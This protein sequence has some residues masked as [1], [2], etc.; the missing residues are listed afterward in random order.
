MYDLTYSTILNRRI[1]L[2]IFNMSIRTSLRYYC[3]RF[4][5]V[6][7]SLRNIMHCLTSVQKRSFFWSVF[8]CIRT[9]YGKIVSKYGVFSGPYFPVFGLTTP[10][11]SI[12]S[13]NTGKYGP[14]K[15]P[16]LDTFHA[17]IYY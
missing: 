11:L 5:M 7:Q 13:P 12:F 8:S 1:S 16:Y 9:E 14:E 10:Y 2:I 15:T 17:V 4:W 3:L 6:P